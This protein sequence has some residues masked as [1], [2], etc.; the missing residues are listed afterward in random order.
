MSLVRFVSADFLPK[1]RDAV[2]ELREYGVD[3]DSMHRRVVRVGQAIFHTQFEA[4]I[5]VKALAKDLAQIALGS[6]VDILDSRIPA[7]VKECLQHMC[8]ENMVDDSFIFSYS[9]SAIPPPRRSPTPE[10]G[11]PSAHA[12]ASGTGFGASS[13]VLRDRVSPFTLD[14][15]R[16]PAPLGFMSHRILESCAASEL[17]VLGDDA[18]NLSLTIDWFRRTLEH[19]NTVQG[20]HNREGQSALQRRMVDTINYYGQL[21]L[22]DLCQLQGDKKGSSSVEEL[23]RAAEA[24]KPEAS[25]A[26]ADDCSLDEIPPPAAA[27]ATLPIFDSM[28]GGARLEERRTQEGG[29]REGALLPH[30]SFDDLDA[31]ASAPGA[32]S[33]A[34]VTPPF[35]SFRIE[36]SGVHEIEEEASVPVY[37]YCHG[38]PE[39]DD[40][41]T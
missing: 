33:A 39:E 2:D 15:V 14:E 22:K 26:P 18:Q 11:A 13:G 31:A 28:A 3:T 16:R 7:I 38:I 21:C 41:T 40:Q 27:V 19:M 25:R 10:S 8:P 4:V 37:L 23:R 1:I 36:G 29:G 17:P 30:L 20:S 32:I 35:G 34:S 9:A 12:S 6:E 24:P 5:A